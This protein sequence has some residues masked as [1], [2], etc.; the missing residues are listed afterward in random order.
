MVF[1]PVIRRIIMNLRPGWTHCETLSGI[2][3]GRAE[4]V[5]NVLNKKLTLL[6]FLCRNGGS[7]TQFSF[8][9]KHSAFIKNFV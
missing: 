5:I 6:V 8:Q 1:T 4:V 3:K 2:T 7:K 9:C